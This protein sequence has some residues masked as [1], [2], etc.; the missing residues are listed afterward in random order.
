M[1]VIVFDLDDTLLASTHIHKSRYVDESGNIVHTPLPEVSQSIQKIITIAKMV[2]DIVY[3]ITNSE[4]GWID[5]C[6]KHYITDCSILKEIDVRTR[7]NIEFTKTSFSEWKTLNFLQTLHPHF[8]VGGKHELISF[9]DS[10]F[11]RQAALKIKEQFPDVVVKNVTLA[12]YPTV[13]LLLLEHELIE[14]VLCY[15]SLHPSD[16]DLYFNVFHDSTT[17]TTQNPS[18][19]GDLGTG[20]NVPPLPVRSDNI[21]TNAEDG[22]ISDSVFEID[23]GVDISSSP[24]EL[25]V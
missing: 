6:L 23:L 2:A 17:S 18:E 9:G 21:S 25:S 5:Y 14:K 12:M 11:D 1:K 20:N 4:K 7:E 16:L 8:S 13:E 24:P 3:I 22:M 15:L 10:I 19:L